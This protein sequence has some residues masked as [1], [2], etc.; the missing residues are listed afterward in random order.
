[1]L[2][3]RVFERNQNTANSFDQ[4]LIIDFLFGE[5]QLDQGIDAHQSRGPCMP[6]ASYLGFKIT[7]V[8]ASHHDQQGGISSVLATRS[9]Q[10]L[11]V[12]V[13]CVEIDPISVS[14]LHFHYDVVDPIEPKT[15]E[16]H[17]IDYALVPSML[18]VV[19]EALSDFIDDVLQHKPVL[20]E[21]VV[22]AEPRVIR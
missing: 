3:T 21:C 13:D 5:H 15:I 1:M 4:G 8:L 20:G 10:L 16:T 7:C 22:Q 9:T 12:G 6:T 14:R 17:L 19:A 2:S 11:A 18:N